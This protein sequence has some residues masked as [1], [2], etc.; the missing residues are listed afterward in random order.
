MAPCPEVLILFFDA[1]MT[2]DGQFVGKML[3]RFPLLGKK[4]DTL[5]PEERNAIFSAVSMTNHFYTS[6]SSTSTR[7]D[8]GIVL[9]STDLSRKLV[10]EC[11]LDEF[12]YWG[13]NTDPVQFATVFDIAEA[14]EASELHTTPQKVLTVL[15]EGG[16][17][18][19]VKPKTNTLATLNTPA[20]PRQSSR[21]ATHRKRIHGAPQCRR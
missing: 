18:D 4:T 20:D 19:A 13:A 1:L 9:T 6:R 7:V 12:V 16:S 21:V 10:S 14:M 3:R 17:A 8:F 5:T 2:D 11:K 15:R